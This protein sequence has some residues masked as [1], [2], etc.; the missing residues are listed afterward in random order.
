[1]Y[2]LDQTRH[3]GTFISADRMKEST[4]LVGGVGALGN[5]VVKNLVMAGIGRIILVDRDHIEPHNLSRSVFFAFG[6]RESTRTNPSKVAF[7]SQTIQRVNSAVNVVAFE[8]DI[9]DL[10]VAVYREAQ[11]AFSC[12]DDTLPRYIMNERCI[13]AGI[14]L[15][16]CG[17][18]QNFELCCDGMVEVFDSADAACYACRLTQGQRRRAEHLLRGAQLGC[19][20]V[21]NI[22]AAAGGVPT[23][24][25]MASVIG[26][27]AALEGVKLLMQDEFFRP[28]PW[29]CVHYKLGNSTG[30][31]MNFL[32]FERNSDCN[33]HGPDRAQSPI[34]SLPGRSDKVSLDD[35]FQAARKSYG[36][37]LRLLLPSPVLGQARCSACGM[38]F[39]WIG[40]HHP[41]YAA[42]VQQRPEAEIPVSLR[43]PCG[44]RRGW[45]E[46]ATPSPLRTAYAG[47][48]PCERTL[49]ALGFPWSATY[50]IL[51]ATDGSI[52]RYLTLEGDRD[53][54]FGPRDS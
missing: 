8:G 44:C 41:R 24:I 27:A 39:E 12:F 46:W 50:G 51:D 37:E 35:L 19:T 21:G 30:M 53:Q 2:E 52:A 6:D 45:A 33:L 28:S 47:D 16:N 10:G 15:V 11:V 18:G 14:P 36:K 29:L 25:M 7:I 20:D 17:L 26:A 31:S 34:E 38:E 1:M 3:S 13:R 4:A 42:F 40:N 48:P 9:A 23:S 32:E 22:I 5:E 43:L 54:I 49:R